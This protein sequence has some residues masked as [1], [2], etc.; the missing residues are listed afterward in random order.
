MKTL[1]TTGRA[2]RLSFTLQGP[3]GDA[4]VVLFAHSILSSGAMWERQ[5]ALLAARG[6]RVAR[7][8]ARGHGGS[9]APDSFSC[10]MDDLADDTI[11][12]LDALDVARA[13]Y[14]GLSLG[15]MSGISLGLRHADRLLSLCLCDFRADAPADYAAPWDER[16]AIVRKTGS[17]APLARPTIERWLGAEFIAH[18]GDIASRLERI[19]E[20]TL[21]S[22]FISCARAIQALDYLDRVSE[23][24]VP[25]SLIVG[26]ND[27][28]LP[29]AMS[30]L[31]QRIAGSVLEVIDGAGHLPNIDQPEAFDAALLR[32]FDRIPHE[33]PST[34]GS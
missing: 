11:A 21:A 20:G 10:T 31:Q 28:A 33:C 27:G 25:T 32:H 23:I 18:H 16:I 26:A 4:P 9:Q 7:P 30:V 19:A 17:C 22:G 6:Y 2:G 8:D 1:D 29:Q 13:H 24:V 15:G 34:R 3:Q 14:V 12:V 5:A